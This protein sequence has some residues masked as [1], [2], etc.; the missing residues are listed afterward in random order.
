[1]PKQ[2]PKFARAKQLACV[3]MLRVA[4]NYSDASQ[5]GPTPTLPKPAAA[6][7]ILTITMPDASANINGAAYAVDRREPFR[8]A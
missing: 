8:G 6:A 5:H 3:K 7:P 1:M 4:P 2:Q